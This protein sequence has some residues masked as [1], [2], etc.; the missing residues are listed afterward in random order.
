[1]ATAGIP[2]GATAELAGRVLLASLFVIEAA[3]KLWDTGGALRYM[4]AYGLPAALLP[5]AIAV[6]LGCG[7]AIL[8]GWRTQIAAFLLAGFCF[9]T[10]L[11]FHADLAQRAQQIQLEKDLALAGALLILAARGAGRFSIDARLT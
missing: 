5:L 4:A 2:L 7:I 8:L 9:L 11:I 1:M 6:E 3:D 10:A